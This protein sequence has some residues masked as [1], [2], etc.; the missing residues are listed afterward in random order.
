MRT[1]IYHI[2]RFQLSWDTIWI[3]TN[4]EMQMKIINIIN[5]M[6]TYYRKNELLS[7]SVSSLK[8]LL[9]PLICFVMSSMY[10]RITLSMLTSLL[11]HLKP[12]ATFF[13]FIW[14]IVRICQRS[15]M[16]FYWSYCFSLSF[17]FFNY[18]HQ[19]LIFS[20]CY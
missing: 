12:L 4:S 19:F 10:G 7:L 6:N 20:N 5:I 3:L 17:S 13:T 15:F 9:S 16:F 2:H 8:F 11:F 18:L 1:R 14:W